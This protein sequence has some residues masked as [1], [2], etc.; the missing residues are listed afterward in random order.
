MGKD[1]VPIV[2]GS[3]A[4]VLAAT[5]PVAS[6]GEDGGNFGECGVLPVATQ[7][8]IEAPG[9]PGGSVD[10]D[11]DVVPAPGGEALP[12]RFFLSAPGQ[13]DVC[14]GE[15]RAGDPMRTWACGGGALHA[16]TLQLN[17]AKRDNESVKMVLRW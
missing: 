7:C 8:Y 14:Q 3:V 6:A 2:L 13:P 10:I 12:N 15:F 11:I 5:T 17:V 4:V 9:F 1:R 16:G